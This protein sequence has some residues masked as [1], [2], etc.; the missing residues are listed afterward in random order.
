V[1]KYHFRNE[2]IVGT[3][4]FVFLS[5]KRGLKT[6]E[7]LS[8][9]DALWLG[10]LPPAGSSAISMEMNSRRLSRFARRKI[11]FEAIALSHGRKDPSPRHSKALGLCRRAGTASLYLASE[12]GL[13]LAVATVEVLGE[14]G[15]P[16]L[17]WKWRRKL[18]FTG[19][20]P[21]VGLPFENLTARQ[22]RELEDREGAREMSPKTTICRQMGGFVKVGLISRRPRPAG[23]HRQAAF[24]VPVRK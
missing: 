3:K 10:E 5:H 6:S 21:L 2:T 14:A 22:R 23:E 20:T 13:V 12:E 1:R 18:R 17:N 8:S 9:A 24:A 15:V 11:S 7:S 4:S 16:L 19:S